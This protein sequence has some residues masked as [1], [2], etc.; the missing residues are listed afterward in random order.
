MCA[1]D[2]TEVY[3]PALFNDRSMQLGL[4]GGVA[5]EL[6]TGWNLET[7]SR[8]D[9]CSSELQITRLLTDATASCKLQDRKS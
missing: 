6:Q 8:R 9:R 4:S 3:Q 5:A 2:L 7:K 1:V